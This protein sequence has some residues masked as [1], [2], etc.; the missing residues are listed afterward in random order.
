[1]RLIA[2][3]LAGVS[4]QRHQQQFGGLLGRLTGDRVHPLAVRVKRRLAVRQIGGN[5]CGK[6]HL[7]FLVRQIVTSRDRFAKEKSEDRDGRS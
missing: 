6:K 5:G 2:A 4:G 7:P 3:R 1:M